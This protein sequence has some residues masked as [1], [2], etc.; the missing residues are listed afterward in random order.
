MKL[1]TLMRSIALFTAVLLLSSCASTNDPKLYVAEKPVLELTQFFNGTIDAWGMFQ[2]RSGKI[3]KRFTVVMRCEWQGDT[4]TLDEDFTYSDGTRQKRIWTLKKT[5][6]GKFTGTAPDV[7]GEAQGVVSGNTLHWNY[8]LALPVDGRI[9]H[10]D[11]D[12]WM[13]LM[14]EKVMLNRAIMSKYGIEL[15]SVTLSFTKRSSK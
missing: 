12:D 15:G 9:I 14:D 2:D 1:S 7:I 3:V 10:V 11:F 5:S 8:V 4:G 6:A 13:V